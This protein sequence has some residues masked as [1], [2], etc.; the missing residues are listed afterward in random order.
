MLEKKRVPLLLTERTQHLEWFANR[1]RKFVKHVFVLQGG[2]KRSEREA[3][4]RALSELPDE[5]DRLIL[6]TGRYVGEGFDDPRL[7]TLFLA[8]PISWQGT[9]Q[10]YVGRLHRLHEGKKDIIVYDYVDSQVPVLSKM[11]QKRL[12][13]YRAMGYTVNEYS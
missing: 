10:Q 12:K 5:E 6:A 9:L 8:L 7:D 4:F 11:Y 2:M 3:I 13:K 1:F